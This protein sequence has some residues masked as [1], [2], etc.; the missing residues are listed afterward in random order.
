M[1]DDLRS[2]APPN[3]PRESLRSARDTA[4]RRVRSLHELLPRPSDYRELRTSWA[5]DLIAGITVGI[6][7]LPLALGF[8]VA[9][10]VGAAAGIVTAVI[11]GLVAAIF[12]GSH[13]QVS[14]PTGAMTVVLL[15]LIAQHGVGSIPLVAIMA[16]AVVVFA[17]L[18]GLGRT[19][20]LIPTPVVEGFTM[21]IGIIIAVQ[22]VPLLLGTSAVKHESTVVSSWLTALATDWSSAWVPLGVGVLTLVI[23]SALT[24]FAR[25]LPAA[26]IAII[27]ATLV[28]EFASLDAARIGAL[29]AGLP[30]PQ[31]PQM[32]LGLIQQLA[33]AAVAVAALAALESL[34]SA[35]VA[36]GMRPDVPRTRPNR[37][38][39]GQGLANMASG[40][41]GGLPATGA[42]ART[43]V[44]VR[45]GAR[46]RVGSISHAVVLL[47]IIMALAPLVSRIPLAALAGVLVGTAL[48]M[49]DLLL[50]SRI[51]RSTRADRN[52]FLLTLGCTVVLDLIAAV[53][54][55][56]LMAG[57]MSLRH[58]ASYSVVRRQTL[59]V[60]TAQ[61]DVDIPADAPWLRPLV[62]L[63]R[64]DGALF[65]SDARRFVRE[66][67]GKKR[68]A[69]IIR[70]HRLHVMDASGAFALKEAR[71][72]MERRGVVVLVQGMTQS[73]IRTALLLDAIRPEQHF[74]ELPDAL[75]AAR[76]AL[77]PRFAP[78]SQ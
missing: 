42:I 54:L 63:V 61:G 12:G 37:E 41:F 77:A 15:P 60:A 14:G 11:A 71:E 58:M 57:A 70:F 3:T 7:A 17:G 45:S 76:T 56:V 20:D 23:S 65:Y 72:E 67:T 28:V 74:A 75:D 51:V 36:D 21:G 18:A 5:K 27:I 30:M 31:L 38:L 25:K 4:S 62:G 8:G 26:L 43:A 73:Q 6:V 24:R 66:V 59:P 39:V 49:I 34:L 46:T 22:Q 29:P 55:G 64:V 47:V 32:S 35:R 1:A 19:V 53:L 52:T 40:L 16:G 2:E 48:R 50:A 9:S 44:N 13:L 78:P 68:E 10:G 69:I 33:P